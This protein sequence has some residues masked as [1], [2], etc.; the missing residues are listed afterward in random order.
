M[1][2]DPSDNSY[3][4]FYALTT[5]YRMFRVI[6]EAVNSGII[7]L[8]D[9]RERTS[10]DLLAATDLQ[11]EAGARFIA[12]LVNTGLLEVSSGRLSLSNF[13]RRF[14]SRNSPASQRTVLE[15]EPILM[16][17]WRGLG[18]VLR[19]GQGSLFSELSQA[20]GQQRLQL[21]QL[22]M[23]EAASVRSPE[24]W[25]ALDQL[26]E[27]GIIIDIGAG[28][29]IYL[30][31]FLARYPH[32]HGVACDL[33]EVCARLTIQDIPER[34]SQYPGNILD[35][36]E[37]AGLVQRYR[38]KAD[39]LLFSNI[40]HCYSPGENREL[41]QQ[42]GELLSAEGLLVVHDFYR[43]ANS[44]GALYDLHMLVNTY[45]GR[46]YSTKE[47]AELLK[48]AGF[49]RHKLYQLPSG[50]LALVAWRTAMYQAAT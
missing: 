13:S 6:S 36:Q 7:D 41:L 18:H 31:E 4:S 20:E 47:I 24:L 17:N 38:T 14:L 27:E 40:L 15:F 12:L 44:L 25:N 32:W 29:G 33:P 35:P 46:S 48:E 21:F 42:A 34:V 9:E 16:E 28:N 11:A 22:A 43:D 45:N 26:P 39:L 3:T 1:K 49:P 5:G 8:L 10:E 19:G 50:S 30:R 2:I 23:G 37:L